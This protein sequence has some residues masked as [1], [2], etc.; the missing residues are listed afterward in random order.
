MGKRCLVHHCGWVRWRCRQWCWWQQRWVGVVAG[1][2]GDGGA[3]GKG[4]MVAR[5]WC[6]DGA[7]VQDNG[8]SA[9]FASLELPLRP[10]FD[11]KECSLR[12][13]IIFNQLLTF[14]R[15]KNLF[16]EKNNFFSKFHCK[17][18]HGYPCFCRRGFKS[19]YEAPVVRKHFEIA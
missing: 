7:V 11:M 10:L 2:G 12:S 1:S 17:R 19:K 16:N 4:M 13:K 8:Q 9:P 15:S 18:V 3:G 5:R 14:Q 6:C